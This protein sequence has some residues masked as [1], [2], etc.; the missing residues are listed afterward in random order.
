MMRPSFQPLALRLGA[1]LLAVMCVIS[2]T[3]AE[4]PRTTPGPPSI[5]VTGEGEVSISPDR[6]LVSIAIDTDAPTSAAAAADNAGRMQSVVA[7]L[8]AAGASATDIR[9]QA[10]SVQ[11]QWQYSPSAPPRRKGYRASM[12]L[13]L[14]VSNLPRLGTWIDAALSGGASGIGEVHLDS[15]Q[16]PKARQ[17]ALTLAVQHAQADAATLARAAGGTLGALLE[18][19]TQQPSFQ[20]GL[21]EV[22]VTAAR[23]ESPETSFQN[24]QLQV[25]AVVLARWLFASNPP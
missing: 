4:E 19:S 20:P 8:R 9:T 13:Q 18:L 22:L 25:H 10:Y 6:A 2:A 12:Q 5:A 7:A 23:R 24:A 3:N 14:T 17:Q 16:L 11:P 15:S 1:S 21:Q